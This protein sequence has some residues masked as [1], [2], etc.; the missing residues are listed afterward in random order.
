VKAIIDFFWN[1]TP[2]EFAA[3]V[4]IAAFVVKIVWEIVTE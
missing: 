2:G 4:I 1:A 3:W